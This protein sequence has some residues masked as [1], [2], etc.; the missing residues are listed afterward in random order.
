MV[1]EKPEGRWRAWLTEEERERVAEIDAAEFEVKR[2][3]I[4]RQLIANRA[5]QRA[6]YAERTAAPEK[7]AKAA[8][9]RRERQKS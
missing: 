9:K 5:L 2:M 3:R 7:P 1:Y 8:L 4:E 6:R